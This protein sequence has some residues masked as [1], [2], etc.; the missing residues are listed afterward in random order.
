MTRRHAKEKTRKNPIHQVQ[1]REVTELLSTEDMDPEFNEATASPYTTRDKPLLPMVAL[2]VTPKHLSYDA[3]KVKLHE[4]F[5][6]PKLPVKRVVIAEEVSE[7]GVPHFHL[8]MYLTKFKDTKDLF[9][10]R[11]LSHFPE[12]KG[13][14]HYSATD[15]YDD[16]FFGYVMKDKKYVLSPDWTPEDVALRVSV[17]DQHMKDKAQWNKNWKKQN[18]LQA[19][20]TE[21]AKKGIKKPSVRQAVEEVFNYYKARDKVMNPYY[22]KNVAFTIL[23]RSDE[24]VA[25]RQIDTMV[26]QLESS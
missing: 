15:P 8:C 18:V 22:M 11:W 9:V 14:R 23:H 13:N 12:L 25:E 5:L 21:L 19:C 7:D 24:E 17:Y 10:R 16:N 2:R 20:L 1:T 6:D 4:Y 3:M 26:F